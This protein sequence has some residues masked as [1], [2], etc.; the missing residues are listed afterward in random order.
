MGY[1]VRDRGRKQL[2]YVMPLHFISCFPR[3]GFDSV[4]VCRSHI[5]GL[6]GGVD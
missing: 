5:S 2:V 4:C 1:G 6:S 3:V